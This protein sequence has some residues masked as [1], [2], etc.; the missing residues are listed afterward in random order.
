MPAAPTGWWISSID[1][2][3]GSDD[4]PM[5]LLRFPELHDLLQPRIVRVQL[6]LVGS[7]G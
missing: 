4:R 5:L 7:P 2:T 1:L 6:L 3:G